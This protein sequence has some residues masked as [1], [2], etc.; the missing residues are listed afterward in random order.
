MQRMDRVQ[1]RV[2]HPACAVTRGVLS[3]EEDVTGAPGKL[4][5]PRGW[6]QAL[7]SAESVQVLAQNVDTLWLNVRYADAQGQPQPRPLDNED[8]LM[9][10]AAYK[11]QAQAAGQNVPT[12]WEYDGWPLWM[13][14]RGS[15]HAAWVLQCP[16]FEL[17]V[18]VGKLTGVIARVKLSSAGLWES[19]FA[20]VVAG[21]EYFLTQFFGTEQ[22]HLQ[23]S[24]VHLATDVVGLPFDLVP[25][26]QVLITRSRVARVHMAQEVAVTPCRS[27]RSQRGKTGRVLEEEPVQEARYCGRRLQTLTLGTHGSLV[28]AQIYDKTAEVQRSGKQWLLTC[29]Q[30]RGWDGTDRIWRVEVRLRRRA[31]AEFGVEDPYRLEEQLPGLWAALVGTAGQADGW[32]RLVLPSRRDGNRTRWPVAPA[33]RALQRWDLVTGQTR[34][35]AAVPL[36]RREQCR[37]QVRQAY[38]SI[39]GYLLTLMAWLVDEGVL[40]ETADLSQMLALLEREAR[41]RLHLRRSSV[42]VEVRRRLARL[43]RLQP[44]AVEGSAVAPVSLGMHPAIRRRWYEA[45]VWGQD[46]WKAG[47]DGSRADHLAQ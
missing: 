23:V 13:W 15:S 22:L 28:S 40:E 8:L 5:Q 6:Y 46:R 12:R 31:L 30:A 20:T 10:L 45:M 27:N 42:R 39:T 32:L 21:V 38:A 47:A 19:H 41:I 4:T 36:E 43:R 24:E 14:P 17:F 37:R 1:T 33:W 34:C 18:D 29:W 2:E 9:E 35:Q 11:Q 26:Q 44:V 16:W 7:R 25:W 3:T